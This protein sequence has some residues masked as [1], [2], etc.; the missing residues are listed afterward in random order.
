VA[1]EREG[2]ILNLNW[3]LW[4]WGPKVN[5]NNLDELGSQLLLVV[6]PYLAKVGYWLGKDGRRR[7]FL[8]NEGHLRLR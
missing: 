8:Y 1:N 3:A 6:G 2:E 7:F 4:P 5:S